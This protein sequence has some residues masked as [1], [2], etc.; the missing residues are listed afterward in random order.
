MDTVPK[1]VPAAK[2]FGFTL[3]VTELVDTDPTVPDAWDKDSQLPPEFAVP[4]A[5]KLSATLPVLAI[6]MDCVRGV[7]EPWDKEKLRL[8]GLTATAGP[9]VS[10]HVERQGVGKR[11]ALSKALDADGEGEGDGES[12]RSGG[13]GSST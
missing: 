9:G 7:A 2:P 5:V 10:R 11:A 6:T 3:T 12:I 1:Y 8:P 13:G 4:L